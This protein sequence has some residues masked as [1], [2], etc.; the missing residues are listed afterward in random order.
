MARLAMDGDVV[1]STVVERT[2]RRLGAAGIVLPTFA[3]LADPSTIS[4]GTGAALASIDPDAA[5]PA[6]LF[7][8]HWHNGTD[9]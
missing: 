4:S 5:H 9:R 2:A 7:R 8:V 6:N 3:E 1:D